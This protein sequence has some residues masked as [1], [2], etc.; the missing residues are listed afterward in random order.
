MKKVLTGLLAF[1]PIVLLGI[2]LVM[3]FA[4]MFMFGAEETISGSE[5]LFPLIAFVITCLTV[6]L[7]YAAIITFIIM[8]F[9]DDSLSIGWKIG[10]SCLL[11]F[12][13]VFVFPIFWFRRICFKR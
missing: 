11:Y 5:M 7:T 6:I 1:L 13:N 8:V 2:S 12:F 9:M 3:I 4:I 10:W